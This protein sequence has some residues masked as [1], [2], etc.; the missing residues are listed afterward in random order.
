MLF[1]PFLRLAYCILAHKP[2]TEFGARATL[3]GKPTPLFHPAS[4][5][6]IVVALVLVLNLVRLSIAVGVGVAIAVAVAVRAVV[7]AVAV[8]VAMDVVVE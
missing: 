1:T 8:G 6:E 2:C 3:V 4:S 5:I 7:V